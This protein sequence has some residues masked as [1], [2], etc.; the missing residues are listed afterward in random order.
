MSSKSD[1][2]PNL[3]HSTF[4]SCTRKRKNVKLDVELTA[5]CN[6]WRIFRSDVS[7]FTT[8]KKNVK[9]KTMKQNE[10]FLIFNDSFRSESSLL[11]LYIFIS[12][13]VQLYRIE[14][15]YILTFYTSHHLECEVVKNTPNDVSSRIVVFVAISCCELALELARP[16][17]AS[18]KPRKKN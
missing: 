18:A 5:S 10:T 16:L 6:C 13:A 11:S 1:K 4:Q 15:F 3:K 12:M 7:M 8:R 2:K 14:F 9:Q 17:A